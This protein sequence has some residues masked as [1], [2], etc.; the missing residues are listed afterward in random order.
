MPNIYFFSVTI[1]ILVLAAI[2]V[3]RHKIYYHFKVVEHGKL[4]RAGRLSLVGLHLVCRKYNIKTIISLIPPKQ[5]A[6][7]NYNKMEERFCRQNNITLINIPLLPDNPPDLEQHDRPQAGGHYP[8]PGGR[9]HSTGP[10]V[11][12]R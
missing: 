2:A 7:Q 10:G 3:L 6:E 12:P 4:Y 9:R 8:L 1:F 5:S 11:V